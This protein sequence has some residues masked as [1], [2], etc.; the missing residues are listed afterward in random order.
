MKYRFSIY[1]DEI[2]TILII[3]PHLYTD[4]K[5]KIRKATNQYTFWL[6]IP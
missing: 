1:T 5:V 4:N 6:L 2:L 3:I